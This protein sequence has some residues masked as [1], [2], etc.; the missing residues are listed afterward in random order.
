MKAR[1]VA[2]FVLSLVAGVL[3]LALGLVGLGANVEWMGRWDM[4]CWGHPMMAPR[5]WLGIL[6]GAVILVGAISFYTRPS[7]TSGWG[8]AIVVL[9]V[10]SLFLGMIGI[11]SG[12]LG[13]IGG[14]LAIAWR[15]RE[16]N[17]EG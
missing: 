5:P 3:L 13:V 6:L 9:S 1:P 11:I 17:R 14:A 4:M 7:L 2:A 16:G 10:L 12:I 15:P 8:I